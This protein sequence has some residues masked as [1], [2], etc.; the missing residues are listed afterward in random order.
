MF[1]KTFLTKTEATKDTVRFYIEQG[2]L[3]PSKK[4]GKYNFTDQTVDDYQEII[5][6]KKMGLSITIIKIIKKMHDEHCGTSEQRQQ[7]IAIIDE[8][9]DAVATELAVLDDR[10]QSLIAVKAQLET[11]I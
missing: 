3:T 5:A 2:L 1:L 11:T 9:L 10:K 6:L 4:A 8:A 7:N